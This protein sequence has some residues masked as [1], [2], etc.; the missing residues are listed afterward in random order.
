MKLGMCRAH[1]R[2]TNLGRMESVAVL[3]IVVIVLVQLKVVLDF[4]ERERFRQHVQMISLS[5][6]AIN[7]FNYLFIYFF[8]KD[9]CFIVD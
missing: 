8:E 2:I 3:H 4:L 6:Q 5:M 7:I 9:I 1:E